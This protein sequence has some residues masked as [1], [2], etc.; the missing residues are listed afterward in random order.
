MWNPINA[1]SK[2][3]SQKTWRIDVTIIHLWKTVF[4]QLPLISQERKTS[5]IHPVGSTLGYLS[6][7]VS[8]NWHSICRDGHRAWFPSHR[9]PFKVPSISSYPIQC[10]LCD[11]AQGWLKKSFQQC[12]PWF[13]CGLLWDVCNI[14]ISTSISVGYYGFVSNQIFRNANCTSQFMFHKV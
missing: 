9:F 1:S 3:S 14:I 6:K 10:W 2:T 7:H 5:W 4:C 11:K 12:R 8:L 13:N